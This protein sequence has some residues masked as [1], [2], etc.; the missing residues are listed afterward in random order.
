MEEPKFKKKR[1]VQ[2]QV[3]QQ[4]VQQQQGQVQYEISFPRSLQNDPIFSRI[5]QKI[6]EELEREQIISNPKRYTITCSVNKNDEY[7]FLSQLQ[8]LKMKYIEYGIYW[9]IPK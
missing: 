9:F 8:L 3:Q 6:N 4:Q 2:Q 1:Q 7:F 5:L